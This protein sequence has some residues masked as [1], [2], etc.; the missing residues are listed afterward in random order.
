MFK[1]PRR[2]EA[3]GGSKSEAKNKKG[4]GRGGGGGTISKTNKQRS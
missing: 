3:M 4:A 2:R 1:H